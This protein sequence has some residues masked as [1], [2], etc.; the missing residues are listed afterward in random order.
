MTMNNDPSA[1]TLYHNAAAFALLSESGREEYRTALDE[2]D[3]YTNTTRINAV[4]AAIEARRGLIVQYGAFGKSNGA[5]GSADVIFPTTIW[6]SLYAGDR[7]HGLVEIEAFTVARGQWQTFFVKNLFI[8]GCLE[9]LPGDARITLR[10]DL[11]LAHPE[12]S[13][14][15]AALTGERA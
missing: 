15:M 8:S 2:Y 9:E 1:R 6:I 3:E 7:V 11:L 13:K 12:E 10:P 14:V 4:I 5:Y